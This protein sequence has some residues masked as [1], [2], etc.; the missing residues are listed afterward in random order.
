MKDG[1]KFLYEGKYILLGLLIIALVCSSLSFFLPINFTGDKSTAYWE[2]MN[3][4]SNSLY[5]NTNPNLDGIFT[6]YLRSEKKESPTFDVDG[7]DYYEDY[8]LINFDEDQVS[9]RTFDGLNVKFYKASADKDIFL[10]E[11]TYDEDNINTKEVSAEEFYYYNPLYKDREAYRLRYLTNDNIFL[12]TYGS[13]FKFDPLTMDF[14]DAYV[15]VV[16]TYNGKTAKI[17]KTNA[18]KDDKATRVLSY[19]EDAVDGT[20]KDINSAN[21]IKDLNF[22]YAL[23][24]S[25][26]AYDEFTSKTAFEDGFFPK[27]AVFL[28]AASGLYLLVSLLTAN[29][30]ARASRFYQVLGKFPIELAIIFG[31]LIF[32]YG[33]YYFSSVFLR[34]RIFSLRAEY[35]LGF[36]MLTAMTFLIGLS[37]YYLVF[38][39]KDLI[40]SKGKSYLVKNSLILRFVGFFKRQIL[41]FLRSATGNFEGTKKSNVLLVLGLMLLIGFIGANIFTRHPGFV[42]FLWCILV[43]GLGY[44]LKG[45]YD[46]ILALEELSSK[47]KD[48]DFTSKVD[49]EKTRFKTLAH[50]LNTVS[51]NMDQAIEEALKSERMK[52]ELITNVSHDLKTPLTS[53]INYSELLIDEDQ[54]MDAKVQYAQVINDKA[55]KL[56]VLIE[57]LFDLSKA[58]AKAIDLHM[59]D[60]DFAQLVD[61]VLGEWEDKLEEKNI[62]VNF[63]SDPG[64]LIL[65]LDGNQTYRILENLLSNIYKYGLE[66]TRLYVDL[67]GGDKTTLTLKNISKYPLNISADELLERFTRGDASRNTEG[68]GLGLSIA[69]SL[70]E[71]QGGT[72]HIEIDGDLFKTSLVF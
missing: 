53:I 56:K 20:Y 66:G 72:F 21:E 70:T 27:L 36:L 6:Y 41:S 16:G 52:T 17:L 5:D 59:E 55:H 45:Y 31:T 2:I 22:A 60:L 28:L 40:V 49:E 23:N 37:L 47:I 51:Q 1:N 24:T 19:L 32:T 64:P 63:S 10:K 43:F 18:G 62:S 34:S 65:K 42:F 12:R 57:N 26:P 48:G 15:Y 39:F 38:L 30:K 3:G 8:S 14:D 71:L 50:N 69:S 29:E 67:T 9:I 44:F 33:G 4:V 13:D 25:S 68:S 11:T 61:Q 35:N 54:D 58:T 7:E 46:S